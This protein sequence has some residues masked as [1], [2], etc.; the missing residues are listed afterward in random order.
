MTVEQRPLDTAARDG[1][2]HRK[3]VLLVD[4]NPTILDVLEE[5]LGV[6]YV[7]DR[8]P[9]AQT[10]LKRIGVHRPDV[11]LL[12]VNMPGIDGLTLLESIRALG[13]TMPAF[14]ITGYN[15][16]Q[17]AQRAAHSHATYLVKPVDL[18]ELDRLVAKSLGVTPFLGT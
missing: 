14:V 10:A 6:A 15:T 1:S 9:D 11:L 2:S 5:F 4:D 16:P 18:R 8:A 13:M 7:V 3:H 17:A 12:D